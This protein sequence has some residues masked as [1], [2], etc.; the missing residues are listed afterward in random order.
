L[1]APNADGLTFITAEP[2]EGARTTDVVDAAYAL[3]GDGV[4][5]TGADYTADEVEITPGGQ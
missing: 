5:L 4:D 1:N 3:I 2:D